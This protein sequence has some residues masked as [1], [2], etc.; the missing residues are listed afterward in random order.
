M[1]PDQIPATFD[2]GIRVALGVLNMGTASLNRPSHLDWLNRL[3]GAIAAA[4]A[5]VVSDLEDPE[6]M[7]AAFRAGARGFLPTSTEPELA[8]EALSL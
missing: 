3:I 1:A 4:P 7:A 8:L 6:E 5:V 2:P